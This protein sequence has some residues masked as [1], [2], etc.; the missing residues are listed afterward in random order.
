MQIVLKQFENKGFSRKATELL[1][2][3][4]RAATQ[5]Q[6]RSYIEKWLRFCCSHEFD[7]LSPGIVEV[8]NFLTD[9]YE[10]GLGHSAISTAHSALATF[11]TL[12]NVPLGQHPIISRLIK[13][14]F[15]SRPV[16]PKTNVIW[17]PQIVLK[18]LKRL[19]PCKKLNLSVLTWKLAVLT[20]LLTG[21]RAQSLHMIDIRN[22]SISNSKV[23]IRF[24]DLLK[25]SRPGFQLNEITIKAYAPDKRLCLI[26]LLNEYLNRV[27]NLRGENF[28]LFL[29][30]QPPYKAAS[31]Q[32]IAR[33]IKQTLAKAGL[34]VSIFSPHSTRSAATTK[35]NSANIP[36]LT[37]LKTAGWS[38]ES[39][40]AKYY[41]KTLINEGV[42]ADAIRA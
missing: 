4:W 38:C 15:A 8:V 41:N 12:D 10:Q 5:K 18:Y 6:Y 42:F 40:F 29:T 1:M 31:Q 16:I 11:I 17:D 35:A 22:I 30:T 23:K 28:R 26:V 32:T 2:S 25:Q 14:V 13:G 9:M 27:K 3:S 36:L 33:W 7:P 34:D 37:I 39:T 20:A 24:G 21:Q 19:S